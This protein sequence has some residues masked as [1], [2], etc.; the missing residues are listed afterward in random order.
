[1]ARFSTFSHVPRKRRPLPASSPIPLLDILGYLAIGPKFYRIGPY[2]RRSL[3]K[4]FLPKV[5]VAAHEIGT[6]LNSIPIAGQWTA[7]YYLCTGWSWT[8]YL[9]RLWAR[10]SCIGPSYFRSDD[11]LWQGTTRKGTVPPLAGSECRVN[12]RSIHHHTTTDQSTEKF[13]SLILKNQARD[14]Y[15]RSRKALEAVRR[16]RLRSSRE[17]NDSPFSQQPGHR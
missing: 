12:G 1:M 16:N 9:P 3:V 6:I 14:G 17:S 11:F 7:W 8:I 4:F 15:S 2:K 5:H 13:F 10:L